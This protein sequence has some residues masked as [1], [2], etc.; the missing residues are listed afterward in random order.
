MCISDRNER[1]DGT[2][3]NCALMARHRTRPLV[4]YPTI[5]LQIHRPAI[6]GRG[7]LPHFLP[8]FAASRGDKMVRCGTN[9]FQCRWYESAPFEMAGNLT[10]DRFSKAVSAKRR[11]MPA[12]C[13]KLQ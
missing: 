3:D 5:R 13:P 8:P 9:F 4:A 11:K 1:A 12:T 10:R 6:S 7:G 2:S